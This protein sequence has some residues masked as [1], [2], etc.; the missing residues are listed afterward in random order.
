MQT[1]NQ[2]LVAKIVRTGGSASIRL[3]NEVLW[4]LNAKLGDELELELD[5]QNQKIVLS[6]KVP[7]NVLKDIKTFE[8]N[9]QCQ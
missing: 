3:I 6:K 7:I 2:T 9:N 4:T 5:R 1:S 8:E